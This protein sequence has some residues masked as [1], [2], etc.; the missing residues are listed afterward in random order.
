LIKQVKPFAYWFLVGIMILIPLF[1]RDPRWIHLIITIGM[2]TMLAG[3]MR[4]LMGTGQVS[5]AHAGF[6]AIGAYAS[7][8]LAMRL[9]LSFWLT[10]PLSGVIGG[11]ASI[12]IGYPCLRLKGPYFFVITLAFGEVLRLIFTSWVD[13]FGGAN[14]IS[15]IPYPNPINIGGL[16][17]EF[18]SRSIHYYYLM[19]LLLLPSLF[20]FYR[21]ERFRFGMACSAIREYDNLAESLGVNIMR[22]KMIAF[23]LAC[24]LASLAGSFYAHYMTYI[25]PDFFTFNESMLFLLMVV[26]GGSD[27]TTGVIIGVVLLT[28]ISEFAREAA[29]FEPIIYG[30]ALVLILLFFPGGIWSLRLWFLARPPFSRIARGYADQ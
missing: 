18:S 8:L 22:H 27:S 29:R 3:G 4:L 14:G 21:L 1:I 13:V 19:L 6:W 5:F 10:L 9:G 12:L 2:Y 25:S 16:A 28:L 15:G 26:I 7:T 20:I 11:I 30:A 17:I 23:L 24:I